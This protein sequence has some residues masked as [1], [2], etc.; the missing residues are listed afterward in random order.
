[1]RTWSEP[2]L[3]K[4][5]PGLTWSVCITGTALPIDKGIIVYRLILLCKNK[6]TRGPTTSCPN[7]AGLQ[8]N[9]AMGAA[10]TS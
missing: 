8:L 2:G 3:V 6:N 4:F 1:M 9:P 7:G 10:T 5:C